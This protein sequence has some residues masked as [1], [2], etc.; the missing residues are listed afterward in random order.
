MAVNASNGTWA[1]CNNVL[2][3]KLCKVDTHGPRIAQFTWTT[4]NPDVSL[5]Q[6]LATGTVQFAEWY[7]SAASYATVKTAHGTKVEAIATYNGDG[8]A[9]NSAKPILNNTFFTDAMYMLIDFNTI[10]TTILDNGI[11]GSATPAML[12]CNLYPATVCDNP[13]PVNSGNGYV[14]QAAYELSKDPYLSVSPTPLSSDTGTTCGGG[15]C[16]ALVWTNKS[17][18]APFKLQFYQ[19][20]DD[21]IRTGYGQLIVTE[22]ASIGVQVYSGPQYGI[23]SGGAQTYITGPDKNAVVKLGGYD[24]A[25]GYNDKP[26]AKLNYQ[27]TDDH[28]CPSAC[29]ADSWDLYT[30]GY[31]FSSNY[32]YA[33]EAFDSQ[34]IGT[35]FSMDAQV[36]NNNMDHA[37]NPALYASDLAGVATATH[38]CLS[39]IDTT[40]PVIPLLWEN[41]L[42]GINVKGWTGFAKLNAYIP[43]TLTGEFYTALNAHP[44]SSPTGGSLIWAEH[45]NVPGGGAALGVAGYDTNWLYG[46]DLNQLWYDTPLGIGPLC[47][48]CFDQYI[49]WMTTSYSITPFS[50]TINGG[51]GWFTSQTANQ[52]TPQIVS[53]GQNITF[54]FRNNITFSDSVPVTAL[55]Y[56]FTLAF[57]NVA[58]APTIP[59]E[60]SYYFGA[61]SGPLGLIATYIKPG[62]DMT[63]SMIFGSTALANLI[64]S[65][66]PV[67]PMHIYEWWNPNT[68]NDNFNGVDTAAVNNAISSAFAMPGMPDYV[69][70]LP[71]MLVGSGPFIFHSYDA[72]SGSGVLVAN[73]GYQRS[74]WYAFSAKANSI[75]HKPKATLHKPTIYYYTYTVE[76]TQYVYNDP[77]HFAGNF[78]GGFGRNTPPGPSNPPYGSAHDRFGIPPGA[79]GYVDVGSCTYKADCATDGVPTNSTN[80]VATTYVYTKAGALIDTL[81][82]TFSYGSYSH[83]AH[84]SFTVKIPING[85][86]TTLKK[87]PYEIEAVFHYTFLGLPRTQ[88][89]YSVFTVK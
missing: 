88:I 20:T 11:I 27:L 3:P 33:D 41:E 37:C 59:N 75:A 69:Y 89:I 78:I 70:A 71:N 17:S 63:I 76:P 77:V 47:S 52:H 45:K 81:P 60:N 29:P 14:A 51:G 24:Q 35:G 16:S 30:Y 1:N 2:K 42:T 62:H 50:G 65:Q 80:I 19:R 36:I 57:L 22:L 28:G 18:G 48:A 64:N 6:A 32:L 10:E 4:I 46:I 66:F 84:P 53:G 43:G 23:D 56:N 34:F 39:I 25:N 40:H 12:P 49:N 26:H 8:L 9:F 13:V 31:A 5:G 83:L 21:I 61:I 79:T 44:T 86:G 68:L 67:L 73:N 55:D 87:G 58:G 85:M 82:M 7:L 54:T 15:P 74:A 38:N 72:V